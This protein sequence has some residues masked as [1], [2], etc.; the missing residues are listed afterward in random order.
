[1][2]AFDLFDKECGPSS[3]DFPDRGIREEWFMSRFYKV[4]LDRA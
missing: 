2:E 4:I 3:G 1:M